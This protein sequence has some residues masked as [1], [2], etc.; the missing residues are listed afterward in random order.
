MLESTIHPNMVVSNQFE[1]HELTLKDGSLVIGKIVSEEKGHYSLVQSGLQ[2]MTFTK[3]EISKVVSKKGSKISMMPGGLINSMNA[4]ELKDLIAYFVSAGDP[5]HKVFR[6]TKKLAIELIRAVYGQEGNPEKQM[7]V[8]AII[9]NKINQR[10]YEFVMN[11]QVAGADPA[12]G[13]VKVLDLSYKLNGKTYTKKVR[14]NQV[15]SFL[16]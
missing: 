8:Q 16:D 6:S 13:V 4:D 5:K 2:P 12:S 11:N 9:Q 7:G 15:L 14:E 1:Q 3:V 10:E